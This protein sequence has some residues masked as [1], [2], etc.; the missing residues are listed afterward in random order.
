MKKILSVLYIWKKNWRWEN[1]GT[2]PKHAPKKG[3][4]S[5]NKL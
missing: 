3:D 2:L 5:N 4:I 1:E